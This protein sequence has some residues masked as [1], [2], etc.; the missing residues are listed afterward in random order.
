MPKILHVADL[1]LKK[2]GEDREY[3]LSVLREIIDIAVNKQITHILICGDLFDS[4]SDFA[5]TVLQ[6]DVKNCFEKLHAGCNAYYITGNHELLGK[7]ELDKFSSFNLGRLNFLHGKAFLF[8]D[9]GLEILAVPFSRDYS[10]LASSV[11]PAKKSFRILMMHGTDSTIYSGPD[12]ECEEAESKNALIPNLLIEKLNADYAAFGHIHSCNEKKLGNAIAAYPGSARVWRKGE[13]GSRKAIFFEVSGNEAGPR[14]MITIKSAGQ[15][16][17]IT[18]PV[19]L[20]GSFERSTEPRLLSLA[21]QNP[22]DWFELVFSGAAEDSNV[23]EERKTRL[24][25]LISPKVRKCEINTLK[26]KT[27]SALSDNPAARVFL[28]AMETR[29]PS[30]EG[31]EMEIWLKA[32]MLGLE[33]ID[34]AI[35]NS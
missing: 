4:F 20:D 16:R 24:H 13:K 35:R 12:T 26:I 9:S 15:Y 6:E 29:R 3:G 25:S 27:L 8:E 17:E 1:H 19:K 28:E 7:S 2:D 32:R 5:D 31:K 34:N 30:E 18:V 33:E 21:A 22:H 10:V 11:F 14:E 23:L